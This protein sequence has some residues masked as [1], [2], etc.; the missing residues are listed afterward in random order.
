P[1]WL[2]EHEYVAVSRHAAIPLR[3]QPG[4]RGRSC[5]GEDTLAPI[6]P[7]SQQ[8]RVSATCS[9]TEHYR[10]QDSTFALVMLRHP[11]GKRIGPWPPIA[12]R[13]QVSLT[14]AGSQNFNRAT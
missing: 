10:A 6:Q 5:F 4:E 9:V 12:A 3:Q 2:R 13:H 14:I 1:P 8:L 11:S 7:M